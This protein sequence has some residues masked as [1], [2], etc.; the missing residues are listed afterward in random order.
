MRN[1]LIILVIFLLVSIKTNAQKTWQDT[2]VRLV[3]KNFSYPESKVKDKE[4]CIVL[5]QFKK[6]AGKIDSIVVLN[7]V[8][9]EFKKSVLEGFS[10]IKRN[11]S[12]KIKNNTLLPVY[13]V[14]VDQSQ[15]LANQLVQI[16]PSTL[17]SLMNEYKKNR[18]NEMLSHVVL[19]K[20]SEK[21]RVE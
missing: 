6:M 9:K 20:Y 3:E 1:S 11:L 12:N 16:E 14:F 21:R 18:N 2:L 10:K 17:G 5:L 4:S 7:D 8:Q 15:P 13:F 19:L